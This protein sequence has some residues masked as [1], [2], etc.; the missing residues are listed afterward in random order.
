M[1]IAATLKAPQAMYG[2]IVAIEKTQAGVGF[3]RASAVPPKS[4]PSSKSI[5]WCSL[6]TRSM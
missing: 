1:K 6:V 3:P 5:F 4:P 2:I